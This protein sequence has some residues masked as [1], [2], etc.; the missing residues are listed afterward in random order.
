[1]GTAT[2]CRWARARRAALACLG[3]TAS[4]AL[5][6]CVPRAPITIDHAE[7]RGFGLGVVDVAIYLVVGNPTPYDVVVGNVRCN[8]TFGNGHTLGPLAITVNQAIAARGRAMISVTTP[9]PWATA[10]AIR[11]ESASPVIPYR[12]IG[13]AAITASNGAAV[14]YRF[15]ESGAL[16]RS[17][18]V[19]APGA[20]PLPLPIRF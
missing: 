20:S 2:L 4:A 3:L 11:S 10:S 17:S 18:I 1:M 5:A 13:A 16:P 6:S 14:D 8:V 15:D 7:V 9:I 19:N 12:M